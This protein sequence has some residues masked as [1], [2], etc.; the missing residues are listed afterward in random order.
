MAN[1]TVNVS[2]TINPGILVCLSDPRLYGRFAA[3]TPYQMTSR[4]LTSRIRSVED[5]TDKVT[6]CDVAFSPWL[7]TSGQNL[8]WTQKRRRR[9]M[10]PARC[11]RVPSELLRCRK[12]AFFEMLPTHTESFMQSGGGPRKP[13]GGCRQRVE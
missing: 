6:S 2:T 1:P 10:R 3:Q 9:W 5:R 8:I 13:S 11:R 7:K 12:P 4:D